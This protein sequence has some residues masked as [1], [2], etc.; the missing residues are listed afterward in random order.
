MP[1]PAIKNE[2][3]WRWGV[4]SRRAWRYA[5]GWTQAITAQKYNLRFDPSGG[6]PMSESRISAYERWPD[7][8]SDRPSMRVLAQ[9]AELWE[10]TLDQV[11]DAVD[12]ARMPDTDRRA[13]RDMLRDSTRPSSND[14]S[15]VQGPPATAYREW[16]EPDTDGRSGWREVV[17]MAAHES[18]EHAEHAERRD[19][20]AAT[21][22]QMRA[23]VVRLS[24]EHMT[25][26]P[27]TVFRDARQLRRRMWVALDRRLW[28]R[29]QTEL[30][31]LLGVLHV[32]MAASAN[33]LGQPAAAEELVR[34]G[35]AYATG[36]DHRPLMAQ[37]R[38]EL[39]GIVY[40]PRPRHSRE[41]ARSGLEYL[42]TGQAAAQLHLKYGRAAARLGDA[43]TARAAITA[44]HEA[45]AADHH[46]EVLEIGGEFGLSRATQ[47]FLAGSTLAELPNTSAE[48]I[49]ELR[50]AAE[51]YQAGPAPGEDH[52][53][54]YVAGTSI[55]LATV[56]LRNG[57][58][59]AAADALAP[60][61]ALSPDRRIE[62]VLNRLRQLRPELTAPR[63]AR[64]PLAIELDQRIEDYSSNTVVSNLRALSSGPL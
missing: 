20:G 54:G 7:T 48:A 9:L 35:W 12:L 53:Y 42:N 39:A 47:H 32:L 24:H 6:A 14:K 22:E 51:L 16:D 13:Y 10:T 15:D 21:L 34:A 33:S 55:V 4:R 56:L 46:D 61:L 38:L 37:L 23:D 31:F 30:Y 57:Q 64:Q 63:Y 50:Q 5:Y 49:Q 11:V 8:G 58:L 59:D 52:Y 44:A 25:G 28:P 3:V 43:D 62:A 17:A 41:L 45:R 18:S 36:I 19:I 27:F 29:D 2:M 60:V 1:T 26:E 40:W